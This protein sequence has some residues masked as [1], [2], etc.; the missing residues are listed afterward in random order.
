MNMLY[1]RIE[2]DKLIHKHNVP[3]DISFIAQVQ[4]LISKHKCN[5]NYV[6]H[7]YNSAVRAKSLCLKTNNDDYKL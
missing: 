7:L 3:T 1:P 6:S 5:Y 4:T 2:L